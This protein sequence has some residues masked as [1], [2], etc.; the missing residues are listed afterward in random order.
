ME[1]KTHLIPVGMAVSKE[2]EES[3]VE[4]LEMEKKGS[5]VYN[6]NPNNMVCSPECKAK[7]PSCLPLPLWIHIQ[8]K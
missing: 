1:R 5:L 4:D 3:A 7:F 6:W 2:Q 8:K